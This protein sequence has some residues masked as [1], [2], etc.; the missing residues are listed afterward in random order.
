MDLL[1]V[2]KRPQAIQMEIMHATELV[3]KFVNIHVV[4]PVPEYVEEDALPVAQ[5]TVQ[6][7]AQLVVGLVAVQADVYLH[8]RKK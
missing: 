8:Q 2:R 6:Q 5:A 7:V 3:L 1:A 4:L